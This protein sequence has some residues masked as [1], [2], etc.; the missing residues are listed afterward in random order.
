M[1]SLLTRANALEVVTESRAEGYV[2]RRSSSRRVASRRMRSGPMRRSAVS[3]AERH[4]VSRS[5]L[6]VVDHASR[7]RP[8]AWAVSIN[9]TTAAAIVL[10]EARVGFPSRL[11]PFLR[12][13]IEKIPI[14]LEG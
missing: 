3:G 1:G 14:P 7:S 2:M 4:G 8:T 10:Y 5:V 9:L 11:D 12:T 13:R 6:E